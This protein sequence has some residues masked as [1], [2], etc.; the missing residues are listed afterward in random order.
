MKTP[1]HTHHIRS[2]GFTI[3]AAQQWC[4]RVAAPRQRPGFARPRIRSDGFTIVELMIATMVF[5]TIL[6]FI[7]TGVLYFSRAYYSSINRT[8]TQNTVRAIIASVSQGIQFAGTPIATTADT[9]SSYFCTGGN[10]YIFKPGVQYQGA[11]AT[12]ANPGLYVVPSPSGCGSLAGVNYNRPDAQQLLG[13][14]MRVANLSVESIGSQLYT[15]S[16]TLVYGDN[17]LLCAPQSVA[18]SCTSSTVLSNGQLTTKDVT[19]RP[20][21]GSQF[22]AV[23]PLNATVQRRVQGS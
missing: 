17:D 5:S 21:T 13:K 18:G 23:S 3:S 7:T 20:K 19:C 4:S 10:M 16:L 11:T 8:N 6:V 2:A 1:R 22:C 15:I 12:A 9:G 14:G